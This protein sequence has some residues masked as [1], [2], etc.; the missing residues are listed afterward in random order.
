MVGN[1]K[2]AFVI[3]ELSVGGAEKFLITL[4]NHFC[5]IGYHPT[6]FILSNRQDLIHSLNKN[7]TV[8]SIIKKYRFDII[9]FKRIKKY[10]CTN[11]IML[12]FC[13]NSYTFFLSKIFLYFNKNIQFYLS[14]HSTRPISNKI[15][16]QNLLYFRLLQK[17]DI[18]IYLCYNQKN[19]LEKKY[20]IN[21]KLSSV[22][23]N[24]VDIEYYNP[25]LYTSVDRD[26]YRDQLGIKENELIIIL[27]ARLQ[28]EKCHTDAF[29]ALQYLHDHYKLKAHLLVVGSGKLEYEKY[30]H[31]YAKNMTIDTFI[32]FLGNQMD[33]RKY[34]F[35]SD[36]FALTSE[37]ETFSLSAL[38][39][40]SFNLPCSLTNTGGAS[41]MIIDG[42]NG[43]LCSPKNILSIAESWNY[44]LSN[45]LKNSEIR[46][47]IINQFSEDV[48]LKKYARLIS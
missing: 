41:E 33:V 22:I 10:I 26:M 28:A 25:Y 12:V 20:F 47:H 40:M 21:N 11:D 9:T 42:V 24:G 4:M 14:L 48:M 16:W 30:L 29:D 39:A 1:H 2:I 5:T 38:E 13:V 44:I 45:H 34:Y 17:K 36:M 18:I 19:Y 35:I 6:L 8:V 3:N 46:N 43:K 23:Y 15:Y 37:S 32:H 7:I 31:D 27:V